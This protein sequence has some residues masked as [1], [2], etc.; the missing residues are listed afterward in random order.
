MIEKVLLSPVIC[1]FEDAGS[2][3]GLLFATSADDCGTLIVAVQAGMCA[4]EERDN[5]DRI[6][7]K[8]ISANC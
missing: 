7:W 3:G 5:F 2:E 8:D 4:A 6:A 1:L